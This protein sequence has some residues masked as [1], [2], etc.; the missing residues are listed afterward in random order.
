MSNEHEPYLKL[1]P[2]KREHDDAWIFGTVDGLRALRDTLDKVINDPAALHTNPEE[3]PVVFAPD[4]E[5]YYVWIAA[6][7]EQQ[8]M[9]MEA[10]GECSTG[11]EPQ[12]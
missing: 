3:T 6:A 7:T 12:P 5:G 1:V 10:D 9:G 2:L 11:R 4:G 8:M